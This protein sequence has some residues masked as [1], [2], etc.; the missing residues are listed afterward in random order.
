MS[1]FR[2][3]D[4]DHVYT[5]A[6]ERVP[7]ITQILTRAGKI[8]D[9]WYTEEACERGRQVHRLTAAYD[10][11]AIDVPTLVSPHRGYLLAHIDAVKL[12]R[13]E[14][15]EI[16]QPAV[17][18]RRDGVRFGGT[19]DRVGRVLALRAVLDEKSGDPEPWH[20]LQTALQAVLRA[21]ALKLPPK[22]I[23]RFAL[24]LKPNGRFKLEQHKNAHDF[25]EVERLLRRYAR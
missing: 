19:P 5:V 18:V 4:D 24:Y 1:A 15:D 20:A 12:A 23:A 16:E 2:Y 6:G 11:E 8:D 10:L 14:F 9:R 7:S 21:D 3:D 22:A 13:A 25:D 17:L